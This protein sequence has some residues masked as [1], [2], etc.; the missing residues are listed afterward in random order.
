MFPFFEINEI[1]QDGDAFA[2]A[3]NMLKRRH[4]MIGKNVFPSFE[5]NE[6]YQDGDAFPIAKKCLS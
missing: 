1:Y 6:I 5:I 3:K 4:L 2:I